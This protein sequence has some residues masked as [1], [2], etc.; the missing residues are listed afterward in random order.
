MVYSNTAVLSAPDSHMNWHQHKAEKEQ[1]LAIYWV[2][3]GCTKEG[4]AGLQPPKTPKT[5][6]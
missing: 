3:E 1:E 6:I 4:A 5:E 2:I